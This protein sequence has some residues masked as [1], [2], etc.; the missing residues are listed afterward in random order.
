M[1]RPRSPGP[2]LRP[3]T[4]A[5]SPSTSGTLAQLLQLMQRGQELPGLEKRHITATH[6]EPKASRLPRRPKPWEGAA[7]PHSGS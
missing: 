6:G 4:P 1:D 7:L 2:A 3:L 5:G